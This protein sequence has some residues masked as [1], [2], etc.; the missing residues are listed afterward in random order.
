MRPIVI[1]TSLGDLEVWSSYYH[2]KNDPSSVLYRFT[3]PD[4]TVFVDINHIMYLIDKKEGWECIS[5]GKSLSE[6]LPEP[7]KINIWEIL[8]K[9]H[10][11]K[12]DEPPST[13]MPE[14]V[15]MWDKKAINKWITKRLRV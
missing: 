4:G 3:D 13:Y 15:L 12:G 8:R 11:Y 1:P 2:T 6:Q 14:F 9:T 5:S 7:T 10:L